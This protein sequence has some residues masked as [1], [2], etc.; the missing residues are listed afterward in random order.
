[1]RTLSSTITIADKKISLAAPKGHLAV[2]RLSSFAPGQSNPILQ[3]INFVLQ[4]GQ[5]LGVIGSSGSGKSTLL[6]SL[7]GVW[8]ETEGEVRL[9]GAE[10]DQWNR[11]DLSGYLGYV[12]QDFPLFSGTIAQNI[13]RFA[14]DAT[15]EDIIEAAQMADVHQMVIQLPLG[16]NTMVG[17]R[18][19][20]LSAG[21]RQKIS[22]ARAFFR[23]PR[24]I[25]LDEPNSNLDSG[26][27]QALS[28]SL[29]LLRK[30]GSTIVI[31]SHRAFA[32]K[33][34]DKILVLHN[35]LQVK[36]DDRDKFFNTQNEHQLVAANGG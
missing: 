15:S 24:L 14:M 20:R 6:N 33:N 1:M 23:K 26:G 27:E 30:M 31:A 21:Q 25:V 18:G 17:F 7:L 28:N 4:P 10:F 12:P 35:G 19:N 2:K 5:T 11:E 36:F 16:Y 3:N 8:P 29:Q 13:S 9:D 32:L 22:L 34:V